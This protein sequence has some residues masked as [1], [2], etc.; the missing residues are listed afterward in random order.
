[1]SKIKIEY[2]DISLTAKDDLTA[3]A[4]DKQA[5]SNLTLFKQQN[6]TYKKYATNEQNLCVLDGTYENFP[7]NPSSENFGLWSQ[8][9]SDSNGDFSTPVVLQLSFSGYETSVGITL[10]FSRHTGDYAKDINIKWYQDNTLLEDE[11]FTVNDVEYFCEK[12]VNRYNKVIITFNSTNKPYRFL[13]LE[14]IIFGTGRIFD[15]T[16]LRSVELLEDVSLTSEELKMNTLDFTLKNDNAVEFTFQKTQPLKF[17]RDDVLLGAFFMDVAT[18]KSDRLYEIRTFDYIGVIDKMI[19]EG[20]TY[21]NAFVSTIV[22][23]ILGSIPYTL[24]TALGNKRLTGTIEQCTVREALM[25]VTFAINAIVD[26]SRSETI[27]I[28]SASSAVISNV[29][30]GIYEGQSFETEDEV[31]EIRLNLNDGTQVS[32][33]NPY[34]P[35]DAY[36]NILEFEGVFLNSNNASTILD[37]L[38]DYYV[39]NKNKST[40][41]KFQVSNNEKVGDVITYST[42]YL[43]TKKGRIMQMEYT[44]NS[45]KLVA[46]AKLK[47]M[48]VQ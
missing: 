1:M 39:T 24:E 45:N 44:F 35:N 16:S 14:N 29:E 32:R 10:C 17:Y 21:N 27:K 22:S 18:R 40:S 15:E 34:L 31:T 20:E 28:F 19:F 5:F 48:E 7:D 36:D 11:D 37:F 13:K 38:Y 8:S 43:G 41:M 12:L 2:G 9:L 33:K 42:E 26:C 30:S 4:T 46:N 6:P 23:D 47:D 25:Q 3:S